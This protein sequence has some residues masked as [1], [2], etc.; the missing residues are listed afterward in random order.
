MKREV[1]CGRGE[2]EDKSHLSVEIGYIRRRI[3]C[4]SRPLLWT[5]T[6][7]KNDSD[8]RSKCTAGCWQ[9]KSLGTRGGEKEAAWGRTLFG[10]AD[11]GVL[12]GTEKCQNW[13]VN[14]YVI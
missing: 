11:S 14:V 2:A 9:E 5:K 6:C 7:L 1:A 13:T 3:L 8:G 10:G 4:S 12:D